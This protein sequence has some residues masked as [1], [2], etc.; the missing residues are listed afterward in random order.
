[1]HEVFPELVLDLLCYGPIE[2]GEDASH[3]GVE[4]YNLGIDGAALATV[5][6]SLAAIEQRVEQEQRLTWDDLMRHL[7][8]DWGEPGGE[9]VRLMLKNVPRYG[10][11]GSRADGW[12]QRIIQTFTR[13]V[14]RTA[15][16]RLRLDAG[17]LLVGQHPGDGA[18]ARGY[19]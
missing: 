2:K 3:G 15:R 17:H 12:A 10:S 7:N 9:R 4:I 5:A 18:S 14:K 19:A 1:M 8:A 13:L 6:D 11:G 16:A